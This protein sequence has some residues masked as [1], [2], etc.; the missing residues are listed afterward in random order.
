MKFVFVFVFLF[1]FVSVSVFVFGK[2]ER[3][4]FNAL[5]LSCPEVG[6]MHRNPN[7]CIICN[8]HN[9]CGT[10]AQKKFSELLRNING[11]SDRLIP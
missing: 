10:M 9:C 11:L 1:V 6:T 2:G 8:H 3:R 7:N 4:L 5:T